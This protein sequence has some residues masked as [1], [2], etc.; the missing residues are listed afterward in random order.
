MTLALTLPSAEADWLSRFAEGLHAA[1]TEYQ[2]GLVGGD[3]TFGKSLV[4]S[5]Q[6]TGDVANGKAITRSGANVGDHIFVTGTVGDA[7]AGLELV[8]SDSPD[9]YLSARFLRPN[10]R[11]EYGQALLDVATAAIDLSDGLYADLS[12]LLAA[13]GVGGRLDFELLPFSAELCALFDQDARL[14]F[15]L[16]GGDRARQTR[17]AV[18]STAPRRAEA[19]PRA[20]AR[21]GAAPRTRI[22]RHEHLRLADDC[23]AIYPARDSGNR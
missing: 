14:Q 4:I 10:A 15:G 6:I 18:R 13:S 8:A 23:P 11:V 21:R 1:A 2:V 12:K 5:V 16:S 20:R 3:T 19:C 22:R 9:G 17:T 7:A